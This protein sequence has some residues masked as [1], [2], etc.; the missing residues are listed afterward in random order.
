M[1]RSP[2]NPKESFFSEGAGVRAVIGG[3][4]IG[5][6]TLVAFYLGISE[7]G[8]IGN[9]GQLEALAKAGNVA[10][11]HALTQGRTMAFIVLTVSQLFY[12]LTMRNSQKQYLKLE[13]SK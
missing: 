8:M 1:K 9:L 5:L 6:L 4:L 7:T 13:F 11:K 3:T 10:A 2:R 12:S